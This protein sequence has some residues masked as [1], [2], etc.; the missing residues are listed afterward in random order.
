MT[1]DQDEAGYGAITAKLFNVDLGADLTAL[2]SQAMEEHRACPSC[3]GVGLVA[4]TSILIKNGSN[5]RSLQCGACQYRWTIGDGV[6]A[7]SPR[8]DQ[9]ADRV[10]ANGVERPSLRRL[11]KPRRNASS[12]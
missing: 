9:A 7:R 2:P 8:L 5:R 11:S 10:D 3:R 1:A 6:F 4:T 12:S